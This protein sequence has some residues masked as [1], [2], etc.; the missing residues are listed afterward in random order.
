MI[1]GMP[2][3]EKS[4]RFCASIGITLQKSVQIAFLRLDA[5]AVPIEILA[6]SVATIEMAV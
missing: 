2:M 5:A 6:R 3:A 1:I 4:L